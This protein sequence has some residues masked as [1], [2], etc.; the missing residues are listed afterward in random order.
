ME[1]I[2]KLRGHHLLCLLGFRGLGYS[3]E[4]VENMARVHER[5]F[6]GDCTVE[7]V[8]G[9]DDICGAC[10]HLNDRCSDNGSRPKTE[11]KD[12]LILRLLALR[13][14]DRMAPA[15]IHRRI[16]KSIAPE[17]LSVICANC[18]WLPLGYCEDGLE[19]LVLCQ[20]TAGIRNDGGEDQ[21]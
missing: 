6:S 21:G 20:K 3:D 10:P 12:A 7:I 8:P 5:V 19:R 2:V 16:V 4:F 9:G 11:D 1:E 14:G 17:D 18:Q 15:E 13:T